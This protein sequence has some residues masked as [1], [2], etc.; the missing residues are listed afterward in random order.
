MTALLALT[1]AQIGSEAGW[2]YEL[3]A[4]GM[5]GSMFS[6]FLTL[7]GF[8][9]S[10]MTF[11]VV[12]MKKEVYDTDAYREGFARQWKLKPGMQFYGP[13]ERLSRSLLWNVTLAL[14]TSVSQFTV[15][16]YPSCYSA[17][18]CVGIAAVTIGYLAASV[19]R[20]R[21]NLRDMFVWSE[22]AAAKKL[23]E[24]ATAKA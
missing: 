4:T 10:A 13:L 9:L 12:N 6:G 1:D 19:E 24:S 2:F 11:I 21:R 18:F 7:S 5:R 23:A 3:Y 17:L 15:G 14:A 20:V 22:A 8:L 16:F